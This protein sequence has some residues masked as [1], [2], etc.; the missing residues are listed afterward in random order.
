LYTHTK[1]QQKKPKK[2]AYNN[3]KV[4]GALLSSDLNIGVI[5][6]AQFLKKYSES[7]S[8]IIPS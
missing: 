1:K 8:A 3:K 4:W 7:N 5:A 2:V 6:L